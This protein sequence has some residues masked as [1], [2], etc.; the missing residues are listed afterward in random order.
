MRTPKVIS[1]YG[2]LS[3]S[4]LST[5]AGKIAG[6]MAENP[7]FPDPMIPIETFIQQ[8]EDHREKTED[9]INGSSTF[10]KRLRDES[11]ETL[12]KS[13]KALSH[14]VNVQ[15]DG[16]LPALTSSGMILEKPGTP[17]VPPYIIENIV[18][19]DSNLSGQISANFD[20]QK[21]VDSYD[22]QYGPMDPETKNIL[23][24]EPINTPKSS[25]NILAPVIPGQRYYVRV[26]ARNNKGIGDWSEPASI[27]A[28]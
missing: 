3:D 17:N 22:L 21:R 5:L 26:R 23:W 12:L 14:Y 27:I 6:A 11:R 7:Y 19:K 9:A 18:L 24:S 25:N 10:D 1:F 4:Q 28:R 20:A 13:L 8:V 15:S 2:K 16:H